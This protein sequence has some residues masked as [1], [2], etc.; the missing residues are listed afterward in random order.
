MFAEV[1]SGSGLD[2]FVDVSGLPY[3]EAR[4]AMAAGVSDPTELAAYVP[5]DKSSEVD[6]DALAEEEAAHDIAQP[7]EAVSLV[8]HTRELYRALG[9]L[10]QV[11]RLKGLAKAEQ[12]EPHATELQNRYNDQLDGLMENAGAKRA[13]LAALVK[14]S[15]ML[16]TTGSVRGDTSQATAEDWRLFDETFAGARGDDAPARAD[17]K[18][19]AKARAK[20]SKQLERAAAT[21]GFELPEVE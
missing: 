16:A 5:A 13:R 19:A 7:T 18:R 8:T 10:S 17:R 1:S 21:H 12:R 2:T 11:S 9:A 6:Y 20:Y 15:F 4:Q 3:D 14:P